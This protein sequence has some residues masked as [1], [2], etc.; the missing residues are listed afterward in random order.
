MAPVPPWRSSPLV[1]FRVLCLVARR[2]D[3]SVLYDAWVVGAVVWVVILSSLS[4]DLMKRVWATKPLSLS[5]SSASR[6]NQMIASDVG[7]VC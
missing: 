1:V 5:M 3:P 2:G 6:K 4:I 7:M